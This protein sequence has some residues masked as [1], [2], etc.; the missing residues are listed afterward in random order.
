MQ[1]E[2]QDTRKLAVAALL[3]LLGFL[4]IL[5]RLWQLQ[6][7]Q[8]D[9]L[10]KVSESNRLRVI[11]VPAPRGIIFDRN[12]IPLV[13]NTP[14]FCA[15]IVPEEFDEASIPSLAGVLHVTEDELREKLR[16]IVRSPFTPVKLK[17]D[18]SFDEV[19]YI[20]ARRSD[21]PGLIVEI[22]VGRN[23]VVDISK[24]TPSVKDP[25]FKDVPLNAL[26]ANG[27]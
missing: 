10:R 22:E 11:M 4:I 6:I 26:S 25:E 19:S 18:L 9:V 16:N 27:R 15:S 23:V 20:E 1:I 2:Q 21:F 17:E 8:G 12:G 3:I 24:L 13:K 5:L 14:Y 7:L